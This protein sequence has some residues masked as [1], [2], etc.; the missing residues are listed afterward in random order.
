[1]IILEF[2]VDENV[3][4]QDTLANPSR[5]RLAVI[6]ETYFVFPIRFQING[7]EMFGIKKS[8]VIMFGERA[9]R[10]LEIKGL[11]NEDPWLPLPIIHLAFIG[12]DQLNKACT[13][14]KVSYSLPGTG[15]QLIIFPMQNKLQILSTVNGVFGIAE[16]QEIIDVFDDF[17]KKVVLFVNNRVPEMTK[18]Q[19]WIKLISR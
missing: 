10:N 7:V 5:E 9:T 17:R 3:L 18:N 14:E 4:E 15:K 16:C 1:M 2:L 13:G 8:R 6:Q 19:D 11:L 12:S